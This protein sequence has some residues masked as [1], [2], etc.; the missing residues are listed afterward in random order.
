MDSKDK[1]NNKSPKNDGKELNNVPTK[2]IECDFYAPHEMELYKYC[3]GY[4]SA[5]EDHSGH[6]NLW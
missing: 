6:N 3:R 4:V 1:L 2:R 5:S